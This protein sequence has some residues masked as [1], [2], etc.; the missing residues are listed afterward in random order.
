MDRAGHGQLIQPDHRAQEGTAWNDHFGCM[1]YHPLF[2]FNQ[3][4]HVDRFTLRPGNVYSSYGWEAVKKLIV[5]RYADRNLIRFFRADAA[6][7]IP[8]IYETLELGRVDKRDSHGGA[9]VLQAGIY[10]GDQLAPRPDERQRMV[11]V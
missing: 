6:L 10:N 4:G 3:F 8:D 7:A 5:A 11:A 1:C 9:G 2:V